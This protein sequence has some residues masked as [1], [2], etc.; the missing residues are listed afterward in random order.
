MTAYD[1]SILGF[2]DNV[3]DK[4]QHISTMYPGGNCVNV[5]VYARRLGARHSAY[6]GYFGNDAEGNHVISALEQEGVE[7]LR[8][9]QLAGPNGCSYN[10]IQDGDRIFLYSN[11]G[12]IRG[13]IPYILDPFDLQYVRQFDVV[14]S[15]NYSFTESE[16]PKLKAAG[17]SVSF[18]FSDDSDWAYYQAVAP[19]VRYA[20]CSMDGDDA[21][22][23]EHLRRV[24]ALG[25][26]LVCASRGA[27]GCVL[28]DGNAF[29]R[30]PAV[31][32]ED[33]VDTMGAGDSL[34]A[35][36]LVSYI[37]YRKQ[38]VPIPLSIPAALRKG[39]E[40]AATVCQAE[41]AFGYGVAYCD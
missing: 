25:P 36:F 14:H 22:V 15:G 24:L 11:E 40:F 39:A 28:F 3:V 30:Q 4:Y 1:V 35:A 27:E 26:E 19:S 10:T 32:L 20:F 9:R 33:V 2:G 41:G 13:Q 16:L 18:D 6:L 38:R 34:I 21:A 37:G 12:G 7:T 23:E 17:V 29:F 31:P 8:C 5:A